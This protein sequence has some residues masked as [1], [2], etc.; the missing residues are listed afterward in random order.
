MTEQQIHQLAEALITYQRYFGALPT[1]DAQW[2]IQNTQ[3]AIAL[4]V[5]AIKN[6]TNGVAKK[7]LELV[8][9][10]S[11]AA[12]ERFIAKKHF[13]VNTSRKA[14]VKIAFL[15]DSFSKHFL[16]KTEE[17]ML[18]G[19]LKVHKLLRSS[20]DVPIMT[21]LGDS[22]S[23]LTTLADM[24]VLLEK[25]PNGEGGVLLVNG[26]ANIF[27]IHDTE[28]KLWAVSA[29]WRADHGGWFVGAFSVGNP[30][31]WFGGFQ[32]LSR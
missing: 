4:C 21:E 20:L 26:G 7:L 32:V 11:V 22:Q 25:Q 31:G 9:T 14:K 19:E 16:H 15:W 3:V 5:E 18:A 24:W 10:V 17:G 12:T 1:E 6:R 30:R 13:K 23:Y 2:A 8:T 29:R 28:G 27:Y